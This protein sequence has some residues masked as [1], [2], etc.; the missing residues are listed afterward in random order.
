LNERRSP[1]SARSRRERKTAA[2]M[3][4][5]YCR[6]SH[7]RREELCEN[8]RELLDYAMRRIDLCPFAVEKPTCARCPVHC[9]KADMRERIRA[10]MRFAGP[11]MTFS[12]PVLAILHMADAR[13]KPPARVRSREA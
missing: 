1:E 8:C 7:G 3:I 10:V 2:A 13:R 9:Y 6:K 11:R 12:H 5:L 4:R